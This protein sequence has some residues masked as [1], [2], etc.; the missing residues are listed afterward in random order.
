MILSLY[1]LNY[2][3]VTLYVVIKMHISEKVQPI[4]IHIYFILV[5]YVAN[6]VQHPNLQVFFFF[7]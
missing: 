6:V 2:T 1:I 4:S 3:N 7:K 5:T